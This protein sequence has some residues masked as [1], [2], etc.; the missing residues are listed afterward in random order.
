MSVRKRVVSNIEAEKSE[1]E[2]TLELELDH[3]KA[4]YIKTIY[5]LDTK[6]SAI[7]SNKT[8]SS[9]EQPSHD[10]I[11]FPLLKNPDKSSHASQFTKH[12]SSLNL[13]GETI[14]QLQN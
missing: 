10:I 2:A 11:K 4:D 13:G 14:L 3:I 8:S 5:H 9:F 6:I 7:A 1:F 12:L